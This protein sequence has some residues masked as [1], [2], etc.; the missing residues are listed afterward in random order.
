[1]D[2]F[3]IKRVVVLNYIKKLAISGTIVNDMDKSISEFTKL[4]INNAEVPITEVN[5]VLINDNF[6]IAFT[7]NLDTLDAILL[8]DIMKFEEGYELEII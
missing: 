1:M 6:Y 2:V 5:E 3:K 7:F 4:I 8:Q